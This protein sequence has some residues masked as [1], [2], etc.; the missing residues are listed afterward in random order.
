MGMTPDSE[1]VPVHVAT[2]TLPDRIVGD[3][4]MPATGLETQE[5]P[6]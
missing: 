6:R 4:G 3:V 5:L 2:V 1:A